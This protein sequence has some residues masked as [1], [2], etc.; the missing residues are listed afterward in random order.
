MGGTFDPIHN[1]HLM[2]AER[3]LGQCELDEVW[4]MPSHLPPHKDA[5]QL[6]EAEDRLEMV[7]LAIREYDVF[8]LCMLEIERGG[9][10]YTIDTARQLVKQYPEYQFSWIIGADMIAYLPNWFQIDEL[11]KLISFIGVRRP[12]YE[13]QLAELSD[14]YAARVRMIDA[15]LLDISSTGIRKRLQTGQ[16]VQ[17]LISEPI[18]S[19]IREKGLYGA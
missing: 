9:T 16:S 14:T 11:M 2:M 6:T 7:R 10:S 8:R 18:E 19:Y 15:P 1:G 3:A 4:F 17:Q 13:L 12:G 5:R